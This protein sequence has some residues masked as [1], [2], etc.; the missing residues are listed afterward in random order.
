MHH[1]FSRIIV[2]SIWPMWPRIGYLLSYDTIQTLCTRLSSHTLI[3]NRKYCFWLNIDNKMFNICNLKSVLY[4][5]GLGL[6]WWETA[7]CATKHGPGPGTIP[8]SLPP[9]YR[10]SELCLGCWGPVSFLKPWSRRYIQGSY[11]SPPSNQQKH[12]GTSVAEG[13]GCVRNKGR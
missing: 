5:S 10:G 8:L 11:R 12:S 13:R 4:W 9:Q 1:I 3:T 2:I 7:I 6:C